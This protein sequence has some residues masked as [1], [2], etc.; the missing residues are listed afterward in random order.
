M[1]HQQAKIITPEKIQELTCPLPKSWTKAIGI[2]KRKKLVLL[3][4]KGE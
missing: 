3:N 1:A 4:T 2:L